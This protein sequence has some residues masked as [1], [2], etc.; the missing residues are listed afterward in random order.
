M[1]ISIVIPNYNDKRIFR[2]LNSIKNQTFRNFEIIVIHG[3][4]KNK[5]FDNIYSN[6]SIDK[7]IY[8]KDNG[9]FDALN[10][11]LSITSGDIIY[12]MGSDDYL[13]DNFVFQSVISQFKLHND[14]NGV[15]I[16]CIF[17]DKKNKTI[18]NWQTKRITSSKIKLG[19]IPPHFSLFLRADCYNEV[20]LFKH[21]EFGNIATD[22]VWLIDFA[23][24]YPNLKI[25][26]LNSHNLFME[27]GGSSTKSL[28][29]IIN[30][31]LVV[32]KYCWRIRHDLKY[33]YLVSLIKSLS[34][35]FQFKYF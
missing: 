35:I 16:G 6:Y 2:A 17:V 13:S 23:I 10:K 20:G 11:G 25:I 5:D 29:V 26:S 7:L 33:W 14:L 27:Y 21:N 32:F 31:F 15:C 22:S 9:I 8:E 4:P 12:L 30:Q 24:I 34:K 3:G 28:K 1:K 18:R 19:I